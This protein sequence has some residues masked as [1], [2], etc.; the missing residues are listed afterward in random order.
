MGIVVTI[1]KSDTIV[2]ADCVQIS[3]EADKNELAC[4]FNFKIDNGKGEVGHITAEALFD[5]ENFPTAELVITGGT[6]DFEGI[7]G[8]GMTAAIEGETRDTFIYNFEYHHTK[9]A[10]SLWFF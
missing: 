9:K 10:H 5:L 4:Y 8:S 6:G 1:I 7:I 3:F 2:F